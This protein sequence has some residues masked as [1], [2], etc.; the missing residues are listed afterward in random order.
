MSASGFAKTFALAI[1][2]IQERDHKRAPKIRKTC[3]FVRI[4]T[5]I[6][7]R[8]SNEDQTLR[9]KTACCKLVD[10]RLSWLFGRLAQLARASRLQRG[11][12][13]FE[14]CNAHSG[15]STLL[16]PQLLRVFRQ[17]RSHQCGSVHVPADNCG[18]DSSK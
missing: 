12:H 13:R 14:S 10:K 5:I 16:H 18:D 1:S 7:S 4:L 17:G 6:K 3:E 11:C 15:G 9:E 2:L 8:K